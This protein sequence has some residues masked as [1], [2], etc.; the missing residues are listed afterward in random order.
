MRWPNSYERKRFSL[1]VHRLPSASPRTTLRCVPTTH[2]VSHDP[3]W[4]LAQ[5]TQ[6]AFREPAQGKTNVQTL[7]LAKN[8]WIHE[9]MDG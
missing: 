2:Y 4:I 3:H 6:T 9:P 8:L 7:D 5:P 1:S